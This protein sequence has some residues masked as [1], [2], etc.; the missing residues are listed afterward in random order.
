MQMMR[1][2]LL[3]AVVWIGTHVQAAPLIET[4][5][6]A[7]DLLCEKALSD[8]CH[9]GTDHEVADCIQ[10]YRFRVFYDRVGFTAPNRACKKG[11]FAVDCLPR[12]HL[13]AA[14]CL[15]KSS[16]GLWFPGTVIPAQWFEGSPLASCREQV[17]ISSWQAIPMDLLPLTTSDAAQ[18]KAKV[19]AHFSA[20]RKRAEGLLTS[21][22]KAMAAWNDLLPRLDRS[23][24]VER[25]D[26]AWAGV[27]ACY[28]SGRGVFDSPLT[29]GED[30]DKAMRGGASIRLP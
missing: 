19:V 20:F 16:G 29:H 9:P 13:K 1:R 22:V 26:L 23:K 5:W 2:T 4:N 25:E 6:G 17:E 3:L 12:G 28:F 10:T 18:D 24:P 7:V 11:E 30:A 14:R 27:L 21:E 15:R 8:S